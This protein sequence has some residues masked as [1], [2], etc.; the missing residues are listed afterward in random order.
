M[1]FNSP[2]RNACAKEQK[3]REYITRLRNATMIQVPGWRFASSNV[4]GYVGAEAGHH[5]KVDTGQ[6]PAWP[7]GW[8][9]CEITI[10]TTLGGTSPEGKTLNL[11]MRTRERAV[12]YSD[13]EY[14]GE[15]LVEGFVPITQNATPG[16]TL[17]LDVFMELGLPAVGMDYADIIMEED[18]SNE[19]AD[20][21]VSLDCALKLLNTDATRSTE[22]VSEDLGID[23]S[24]L[25]AERREYLL[26][27]LCDACDALDIST[28]EAGNR[29]AFKPT[30]EEF[31]NKLE[32][33]A[34]YAKEYRMICVGHSHLDLAWKWRWPEMVECCRETNENMMDL[35]DKYPDY[36]YSDSSTVVWDALKERDPALFKRMQNMVQR[37]Q[38][39]VTGGSWLE[40]DCN[41]IDGES[42]AH[43]LLHGQ[44]WLDENFQRR[45]HIGIN[46]DAFGFN[47]NMPQI[48]RNA[49][50]D[51]FVTQKLRYNYDNVFP[52][53]IFWWEGPDDSRILTVFAHP[54]HYQQML[55]WDLSDNTREFVMNTG[56]KTLMTFFGVGDHGGGPGEAMF[57]RIARCRRLPIFPQVELGGIEDYVAWLR[58]QDLSQLPV[59][60]DDLYLENHRKAYSTKASIKKANWECERLL[61]NA[62]KF[63]TL[64]NLVSPKDHRS[65]L[66]ELWKLVLF[67][68]FHDILPGTSIPSVFQ[69]AHED[70]AK[71]QERGREILND[72]LA[73]LTGGAEKADGQDGK[74]FTVFNPLAWARK[75]YVN[76]TP[77]DENQSWHV[78]TPEGRKIEP[79][80]VNNQQ[81]KKQIRF[82]TEDIPALGYTTY[83]L[84]PTSDNREQNEN[85]RLQWRDNHYVIENEYL[86]LSVD[87]QSGDLTAV[88]DKQNDREVI[89]EGKSANQLEFFE[90]RPEI[91]ASWNIGYT[92][93]SW[94]LPQADSIEVIAD[95]PVETVLRV[96]KSMTS[97]EKAKFYNTNHWFTPASDYPSSFFTQDI[98]L[99]EGSDQVDF[100][101]KADWWEDH[102][103]AKVTFPLNV[104]SDTACFEIPYGHIERSTLRRNKWEQARHEAPGLGAVDLSEDAYGA[105]LINHHKYGYNVEGNTIRLTVLVAPTREYNPNSVPDPLS[106]R[107]KQEVFYTLYPHAGNRAEAGVP[108]RT[109]EYNNPLLPFYTAADDENLPS[110][111]S[112]VQLEPRNVILTTCKTAEDDN[113]ALI[114]RFYEAEG[115]DNTSAVLTMPREIKDVQ[116]VNFLEE[117]PSNETRQISVD[118]RQAK[119]SVNHGEV[120][121]L[122]FSL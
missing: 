66:A 49:D 84:A 40:H 27:C 1:S 68:Q 87:G 82:L 115:R 41:L 22:F 77:P 2:S 92:G 95:G 67:N 45:A 88:Y 105:A 29:D 52:Y 57:R 94:T 119:T 48:Y 7:E 47:Y 98:I 61:T 113:N 64:A 90:D 70:Y 112:F 72:S 30:F 74:T 26:D 21:M 104:A 73:V 39:E 103:L 56:F 122:R 38:W 5:E 96:H 102:T 91:F 51:G 43:Q 3:V 28:L 17:K 120:V 12:V 89:E 23:K 108:R 11:L 32:P 109:H 33:V 117:T 63:S 37:G 54:D 101:L 18:F 83:T 55:P 6:K 93:R 79:Q 44:K 99:R 121:T 85:S 111:T 20:Y 42:W 80:W 97:D 19:L 86:R 53:L 13:D 81:R 114:V 75:G 36:V 78:I 8:F 116:P 107:G 50:I 24:D 59:W 9:S 10:P 60:K 100:R 76:L 71:V 69:D 118:G 106:D 34:E 110:S 65:E 58:Q 25:T 46:I 16:K 15:F 4:R 31:K 14:V 62:E 35:M